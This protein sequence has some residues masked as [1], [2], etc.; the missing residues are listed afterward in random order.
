MPTVKTWAHG[1][2]TYP[3]V[4]A[5][6]NTLLKDA[7]PALHYACEL[8]ESVLNTY[9]GPRL[10]A[11]AALEDIGFPSAVEKILHFEPAPHLLA[12]QVVFPLFCLYRSEETWLEINATAHR[13]ASVWEW[14][15]VLP[16]LTP[17]QIEQLTPI[18]RTVG[19]VISTVAN[20]SCDPDYE[21]GATLRDLSGIQKM[22]ATSVRY[23]GFEAVDGE[24]GKWW[25]AVT[26]KLLVMERDE[27]ADGALKAYEG[28]SV[29][30]D[31][32]THDG[33]AEEDIV[34][35]DI[36]APPVIEDVQPRAGSKAG[37]T[38]VEITGKNF[39]LGTTP[40]VMFGGA[41]ASSVRVTHPRRITC[42]TPEYA[43][44]QPSLSVDVR[45]IAADGQASAAFEDAF[46]FTAP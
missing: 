7:D 4:A 24:V 9:V 10:L 8:F 38:L 37:S 32:V 13:S 29:D 12:D 27:L 16:P 41:Y 6:T 34:Q 39:R 5:T 45:V 14:A 25:R 1:G 30:I 42:L 28:V 43:A 35:L 19:V 40:L 46:T 33:A 3:L 18:L 36:G 21:D 44:A 26:G 2:V 31:S 23:G 22:Q 20:Q 11:Q 17:R 15:Y